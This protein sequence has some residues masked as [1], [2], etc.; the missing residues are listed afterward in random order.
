MW[1]KIDVLLS[2]CVQ[3]KK[4]LTDYR[5]HQMCVLSVLSSGSDV[6]YLHC[7]WFYIGK[8]IPQITEVVELL[9]YV[10]NEDLFGL[11]RRIGGNV[12]EKSDIV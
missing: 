12:F 8:T 1:T 6:S 5:Y 2:E 11:L 10:S 4:W 3:D 9:V 7:Y